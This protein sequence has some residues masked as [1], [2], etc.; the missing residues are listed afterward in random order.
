MNRLDYFMMRK[1]L[2]RFSWFKDNDYLPDIY[3][4]LSDYEWMVMERY[5]NTT[6]KDEMFG[7]CNIPIMSEMIGFIQGS[8]LDKIVQLGHYAGWSS[9]MFGFALR[10]MGAKRALWSVDIRGDITDYADRWL[11]IAELEDI[12][13]LE[14]GDSSSIWMPD[15]AKQYHGVDP[16][17]VFIDSSH[18]YAQTMKELGL[19]YAKLQEGG[20]I[21]LHDVSIFAKSFDTKDGG[22]VHDALLAFAPLYSESMMLNEYVTNEYVLVRQDRCGAG[23]IQKGKS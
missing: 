22:G 8:N 20:L 17:M 10:R 21:F 14:T 15:L 11:Q 5:F 1:G 2:N 13:H 12:V 7:E 6:E 16:K 3:A 4:Q 9:L 19:W 23:I 18:Q